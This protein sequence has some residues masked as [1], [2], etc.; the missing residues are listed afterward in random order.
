MHRRRKCW[1]VV[2]ATRGIGPAKAQEFAQRL[3]A[4]GRDIV[5]LDNF[6]T[7]DPGDAA[8]EF[9]GL[10]DEL[11]FRL[12]QALREDGFPESRDERLL[13]PGDNAYPNSRFL[14]ANPPLPVA[15]WAIGRTSL[16]DDGRPSLGIAG[17]RS[18]GED[19]LA[20]TH[21]LGSLAVRQGW[22]VISGLAAGVDSAGHQG[23]LDAGGD[24][25]GVM[26]SGV[27]QGGRHWQPESLEDVC[28]VSQFQPRIPWSGPGAMQR[29]ATIAALS[30]HVVIIAAGES[31]GSWEMGQLCLK[32]KK[33][34]FV[35]DVR[36]D[37]GPG[38]QKL[39]RAGARA[40]TRDDLASVFNYEP[41]ATQ[42]TLF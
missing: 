28:I 35:L 5:E 18:A 32:K 39:I 8:V 42:T 2:H 38:N 41:P 33:P 30:D 11:L 25:I 9:T 13:L 29:N 19:L 20:L 14:D 7:G 31:G 34:L 22:K 12:L 15:L 1:W 23:A 27:D 24:T 40:V 17:S 3:A 26:A 6:T 37:E 4:Q 16:L 10:S 21:Q 36:G